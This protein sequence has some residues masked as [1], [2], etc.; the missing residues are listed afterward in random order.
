MRIV[1]IH[2]LVNEAVKLS[3]SLE[4]DGT[5]RVVDY[6]LS[7]NN[8]PHRCYLGTIRYR[9]SLQGLHF[10]TELEI[11]GETYV[12]DHKSRMWLG[13][14]VSEGLFKKSTST[15]EYEGQEIQLKTTRL[16]F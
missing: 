3:A 14:E 5:T 6:L 16:L 13:P 12:I 11:D 15:S 1:M 9:D 8:I 10:W 7:V 4:C 2:A